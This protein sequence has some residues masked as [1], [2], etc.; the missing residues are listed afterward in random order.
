MIQR[1]QTIWMILAAIAV[2][3]TIKF[4]FYSGTLA[5]QNG[6]DAV[7]SMATDGSYHLVT[8]TDNFLILILTSALGT[9]IIINI[10]L[11][12]QRS[13]QIRII[14]AAILMEC[15]IIFL[16]IKETEKF[17]QGNFNIWA[18]LHILVIIFLIMASRGIYKDSKL[19]KESNRLR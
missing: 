18:I 10:F 11:F 16:Y 14:I 9:G 7:T 2:F 8:A 3:L 1:V 12:K 4:S 15:L 6:A 19:I 5:I 17:S 13:I